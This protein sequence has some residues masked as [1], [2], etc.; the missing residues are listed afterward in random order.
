MTDERW[1]DWIPLSD[2]VNRMDPR[3]AKRHDE[4]HIGSL[5]D[6]VGYTSPIELD[7]RTG[8]IAAGHGRINTLIG[9]LEA[10]DQRPNG[11]RVHPETGEWCALV[12]R[13]WASPDDA[14]ASAYLLGSNRSTMN[15]GWDNDALIRLLEDQAVINPDLL[16]LSG[17]TADDLDALL[18]GID[19]DSLDG[20]RD[21]DDPDPD[22]PKPREVACPGCG[23]VFDP[24]APPR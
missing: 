4:A 6:A 20:S 15:G 10:G 8:M 23:L 12:V 9:K 1:L 17:F 22:P 7:E 14:T 24:H 5:M 16:D 13:G 21:G 19:P 11:V 18:R 3:N 2:L